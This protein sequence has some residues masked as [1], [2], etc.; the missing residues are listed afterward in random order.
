MKSTISRKL[1]SI[2][3]VMALLTVLAS[4][5]AVVSLR[6][7]N[8]IVFRMTSQDFFIVESSRKMMDA[9]LAQESAERKYLIL[10][11]P[12]L[13]DIFRARNQ[14]FK[15]HLRELQGR[16][17]PGLPKTLA[18]MQSLNSQY[19]A[20]F[21]Q[22]AAMAREDRLREAIALSETDGKK[23]IEDL[24]SQVRVI[25]RQAERDIDSRMAV[26]RERSADAF[27]MT[28]ILTVLSLAAGLCLALLIT[29]NISVPLQKLE[30]AT[31][32]V[33]EGHFDP[34]LR[35]KNRD[36]I[37]RLARA[38]GRMTGRLK[39]LEALHLDASPLTGLPGN[40]AI[41]RRI[42]ERLSTGQ[43]FSLCQVDLDNFKPFADKYGYAWASEVIKEVGRILAEELP[44]AEGNGVF[45]GHIGGDDFV[46]IADPQQAEALSWRLVDQFDARIPLYYNEEDRAQGFLVG[47]DRKGKEQKFPLLTVTV[48]MVTGDGRRFK[49]TLEI[50]ERAAELKEYAKTL[51]GSNFIKERRGEAGSAAE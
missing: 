20:L 35:I 7:L 33:A 36:E 48:A 44:H 24:A 37:G 6:N 13:A 31:S 17:F 2:Y 22:E 4:A 34:D 45:I 30:K 50:A 29:Y 51:P 27:R 28:V 49:N 8:D 12:S 19:G 15:D 42:N 10:K 16:S 47:K 32:L 9:L 1:L 39:E 3:L 25:Q 14:E 18:R 26:I 23:L 21:D 40:L 41:E 46:I 5:Y 38:F 11:D 43:T